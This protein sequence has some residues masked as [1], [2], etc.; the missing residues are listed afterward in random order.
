MVYKDFI[1]W[2]YIIKNNV[3]E[4]LYFITQILPYLINNF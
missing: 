3:S 1:F 2:R 4:R